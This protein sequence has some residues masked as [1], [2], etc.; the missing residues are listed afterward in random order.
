MSTSSKTVNYYTILELPRNCTP[1]E[2]SASY[3]RLVLLHHPDKAGNAKVSLDTFCQIQEA[4]EVL[5]DPLRRRLYDE[6]LS[7]Y[8]ISDDDSKLRDKPCNY[9][10]PKYENPWVNSKPAPG[11]QI[12]PDK[13]ACLPEG[14]SECG[15]NFW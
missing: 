14:V 15:D 6:K 7:L 10:E 4:R 8:S 2:I 5:C 13:E 3:R 9:S 12:S 1:K 11:D